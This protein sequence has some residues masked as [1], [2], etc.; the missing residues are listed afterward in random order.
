M[1][2]AAQGEA[3]RFTAVQEEYVKAPEVTRKRLY[4]ETMEGVLGDVQMFLLDTPSGNGAGHRALP[5]AERAAPTAARAGRE[6]PSDAPLS[7][8]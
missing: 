4:L 7:R 6:G 1:V 2:N 8:S 5:A 3:S